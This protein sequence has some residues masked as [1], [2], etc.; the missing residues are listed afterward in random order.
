MVTFMGQGKKWPRVALL[1]QG[2]FFVYIAGLFVFVMLK[3][4]AFGVGSKRIKSIFACLN[5]QKYL[6]QNYFYAI[7]SI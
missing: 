4:F 7:D 3:D 5:C 1:P 6:T 2:R